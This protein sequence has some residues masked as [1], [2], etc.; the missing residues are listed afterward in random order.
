VERFFCGI[1]L[2]H[3]RKS[4]LSI[5]LVDVIDAIELDRKKHIKGRPKEREKLHLENVNSLC[6]IIFNEKYN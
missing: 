6:A 2:K 1:S 5:L 3:I 4:H